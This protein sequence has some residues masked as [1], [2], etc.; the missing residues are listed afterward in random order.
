MAVVLNITDINTIY[1][2]NMATVVSQFHT[3]RGGMIIN[4]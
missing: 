1:T 3:S 4:R 2:F